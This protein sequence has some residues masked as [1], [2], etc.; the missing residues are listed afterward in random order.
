M[1]YYSYHQDSRSLFHTVLYKVNLNI[2]SLN[3]HKIFLFFQELLYIVFYFRILRMWHI[4][5]LYNGLKKEYIKPFTERNLYRGARIKK[6]ELEYIRKSFENKKDTKEELPACI[7][8]NKAFLSLSIEENVGYKLMRNRAKKDNEE[9][10]LYEL[11]KGNEFDNKNA[12]NSNIQEFSII[13][14][15]KEILFF[16]FSSF[17]IKKIEKINNQEFIVILNYLGK[18]DSLFKGEDPKLLLQKVPEGSKIAKQIFLSNIL[19]PNLELPKWAKTL[20][21]AASGAITGAIIGSF[22]PIPIGPLAGAAIG[23]GIGAY[24][25]NK[26]GSDSDS[27]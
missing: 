24:V 21:G 6:S 1:N 25:G 10:V 4:K 22:I 7:C 14:E 23:G 19:D 12:S 13:P 20:I 11:K 16:P 5:V 17:E 27:D 9:Y 8:Y 26:I 3:N 15:E 2:N 18:Y